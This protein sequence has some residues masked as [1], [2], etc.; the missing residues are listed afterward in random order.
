M[1]LSCAWS[2]SQAANKLNG[3]CCICHSTRQLHLR[4]GTVHKHGPRNNP[5]PGFH[6]LPLIVPDHPHILIP[7][8][9]SHWIILIS[10]YW[11]DS[12]IGTWATSVGAQFNL[13][14]VSSYMPVQLAV[15]S[16][17]NNVPSFST[18]SPVN[19]GLIKYIPRS[20]LPACAFH[21]AGLLRAVVSHP[22]VLNNWLSV[23]DW[24]SPILIPPKRGG[25]RHH[26]ASTIK[27]AFARFYSPLNPMNLLFLHTRQMIQF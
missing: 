16:I 3:I 22:G 14:F 2:I 13:F 8:R 12:A 27:N 4:D 17:S 23:Y 9:L 10:S 11:V 5:C 24:S 6:Q 1:S 7:G 20:A 21:L 26:L 15:S 25:K 19:S 18:W